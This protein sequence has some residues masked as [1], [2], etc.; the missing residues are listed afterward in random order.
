MQKV[1]VK[2]IVATGIGAALFFVLGRFLSFPIFANT[3]LNLQYALLALFAILYGPFAGGL[4]GLIGHMLIDFSTYG[5]WWSWIIASAIVG[6]CIGLA[7]GKINVESGEFGKKE[8]IIFNIV[9]AFANAM[10]WIIVAPVLDILVYSEPANK[11]FSQGAV[12]ALV[13][14]VSTAVLGTILLAAYS[15]TRVKTGS[16]NK[17]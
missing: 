10:S 8:I 17:E 6:V 3:T 4:I 2:T 16:L 7:S 14:I 9:Q 5:P 12:A 13:N 1:S 11:V 15:K